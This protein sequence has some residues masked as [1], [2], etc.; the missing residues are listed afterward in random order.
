MFAS[1]EWLDTVLRGL[2]L[3]A[4]A[5][6]WTV[7]LVRIV[8]LRSFSKMTAFDFVATVAVGSLIAQA[9][10]Q[11]EWGAFLQ[12]LAALAAVFLVQWLLAKARM[13]SDTFKHLIRNSPILLME[14]GR[15]LEE[16]MDKTRVSRSNILEKLRTQSID[17]IGSVRAVV[18]ETTGDI[19]ILREGADERLLEGVTRL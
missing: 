9:G 12:A 13:R 15:Y 1:P 6:V 16:A 19:S 14:R 7:I 11:E 10:T 2:I 8:G 4:A 18:L 5:V 3:S 17:D